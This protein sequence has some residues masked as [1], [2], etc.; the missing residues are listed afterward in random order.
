MW[1][2]QGPVRLMPKYWVSLRVEMAGGGIGNFVLTFDTYEAASV[3][4]PNSA[5]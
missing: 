4:A 2:Q 3:Q 5:G 1:F